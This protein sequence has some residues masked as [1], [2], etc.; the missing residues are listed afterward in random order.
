ML[1]ADVERPDRVWKRRPPASWRSSQRGPRIEGNLDYRTKISR[2]IEVIRDCCPEAHRLVTKH[3]FV[4]SEHPCV[5]SF[6]GCRC[7]V[8]TLSAAA[9]DGSPTWVASMLA[10]EAYLRGVRPDSIGEQGGS[11]VSV[12]E[13]RIRHAGAVVRVTLLRA[14]AAPTVEIEWAA[15]IADPINAVSV[16]NDRI[17]LGT[18]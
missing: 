1:L 12:G 13:G 2:A 6:R 16:E 3:L 5:A 9:V 18:D 14:L 8:F 10:T 15:L 11:N 7:D 4:I 17:R